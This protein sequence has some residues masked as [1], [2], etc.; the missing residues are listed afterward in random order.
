MNVL[1]I[2]PLTLIVCLLLVGCMSPI[3]EADPRYGTLD[4][5]APSP[6][7]PNDE[8][9]ADLLQNAKQA[10]DDRH[11]EA[12]FRFAEQAETLVKTNDMEKK[13]QALAVVIQGYCL[14]QIGYVDDYFVDG[15]GIQK[16][17]ISK[18]KAALK[19]GTTDFRAR[20]GMGLGLFR[21][22]GDHVRKV[23]TLTKG[24]SALYD[25]EFRA[26]EGLNSLPN[27]KAKTEISRAKKDIV[28]IL[29]D[30]QKMRD[31]GYVFRDPSTVALGMERDGVVGELL[32]DLD[33]G[34]SKLLGNDIIY[35]L[36]D[37]ARSGTT[38]EQDIL[39]VD[40]NT[41]AIRNNWLEVRKYWQ[42]RAIKDLQDARNTFLKLRKD[43]PAYFWVDRDLTFTYQSIG[44]FFLDISLDIARNKAIAERVA[45]HEVES[46]ANQI[47]LSDEFN[48][49]QKKESGKNYKDAL[50]Y[51]QSFMGSHKKFLEL[52]INKRD[53]TTFEDEENNPFLTD[54]VRI[55]H[56]VMSD[57]IDEEEQ[58][59]SKLVL[60]AA[61]MCIDPLFQISDIPRALGYANQLRAINGRNPI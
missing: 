18:F 28:A 29:A 12:A 5:N 22:H 30:G 6:K 37:A 10:Y 24:A 52:R 4:A 2:L 57:L 36:D 41:S 56:G 42:T 15:V 47:F 49:W 13:D 8:R 33:D 3:D 35:A 7:T 20:L 32:G 46:R 26:L 17:A 58:M 31:T 27:A 48:P 25:F 60:E 45:P 53:D 21:R 16:G 51:L 59:R 55:S 54:L 43:A 50:K 61:S 19:F 44:A 9:V 38:T 14:L 23:T 40:T 1:R 39:I 34:K 11:Y